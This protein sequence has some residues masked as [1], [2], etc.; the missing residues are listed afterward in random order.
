MIFARI[1]TFIAVKTITQ[2]SGLIEL[3]EPGDN[4][5]ADRSFDIGDILSSKGITI[6]FPPFLGGEKQLS[7][8][9]VEHTRRI[10]ALRIHVERAVGR[11]K[12]YTYIDLFKV[13]CPYL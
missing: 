7:G 13:Y 8:R 9:K 12:Q 5:M 3:L 4:I 6:N 2:S 10:A 1:H 11:M